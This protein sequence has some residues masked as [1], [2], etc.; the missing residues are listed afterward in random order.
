MTNSVV[1][2]ITTID[3]G[4]AEKQL[5]GLVTS[6]I[7]LGL[8]VEIIFLKDQP[9]LLKKFSCAGVKVNLGFANQGFIRQTLALRKKCHQEKVV[10][11]AHLPRSE[12]MC[13]LALQ[14]YSYIVTRHNAESF[15]PSGPKFLSRYLSRF[16][17]KRAFM[18]V[19]ISQTVAKFIKEKH[20]LK[21]LEKLKVVYYGVPNEL[22]RNPNGRCPRKDTFAIG[23]IARLVPQKNLQLTIRT[24]KCLNEQS[25]SPWR[26]KIMGVGPMLDELKEMSTVQGV[27]DL[28]DWLGKMDN[29]SDFFGSINLFILT[30]N[31]EGFGLVLL[32]A[33]AHKVPVVARKISALPEI[34]GVDHLGLVDSIDPKDYAN[35][36]L[37]LTSN[38]AKIEYCLGQQAERLDFFSMTKSALA[39]L[40][41]YAM[42]LKTTE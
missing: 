12:L 35:K 29:I 15:L 7:E 8:E 16:V 33:M 11:H 41:I 38:P 2:I 37:E 14:K 40:K 1:H 20:E 13:A 3:L 23:T 30:S 32:E 4:G 6:Q 39:Y 31:Y 10:F 26:L 18:V 28:V 17:T 19:A 42:M 9:L 24:L 22:L 25:R 21:D 36:I 5:L 27:G 34:L